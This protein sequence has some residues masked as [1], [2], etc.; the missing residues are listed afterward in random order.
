[1]EKEI[2]QQITDI[3]N[4]TQ[5]YLDLAKQFDEKTKTARY[6]GIDGLGL[7]EIGHNSVQVLLAIQKELLDLKPLAPALGCYIPKKDGSLR[8]I[9][10]YTIKDRIKAQAIYRVLEPI[11]ENLYSPFLFSY[12]SSHPSYYAARSVAR[13]YHRYYGQ[14]FI[15]IADLA[16]YFNQLDHQILL[17][18]LKEI[19][20][21]D[22][23]IDLLKLFIE[24]S[25]YKDNQLYTP[26]MGV[27]QGAPLSVLF[28][29]LYLNDLDKY[30]GTKVSLY[31]RVGDD[32]ILF[33]KN[34]AK[35]EE[36][37]NY[38]YQEVKNLK[39][40]IK[41]KKTKLI[42]SKES[43]DFLGYHFH[44]NLVSLD[45]SSIKK[46]ISNWRTNLLSFKVKNE[47]QKM[48]YLKKLITKK[49]NN[50]AN[51]FLQILSQ[52]MMVNDDQQIKKLSEKF[53]RILTKYFYGKY[54]AR[55]QRLLKKKL[56][57]F[58][59]PSI[60]KYYLNIHHGRKRISDLFVSAK[61]AH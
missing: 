5:A 4:I 59:L 28:A 32:L 40:K 3:E 31:R 14:D 60:Y 1:M 61:K 36:L 57:N 33:D 19:N 35:L 44:D 47:R 48:N 55:N 29:N 22:Q 2:F 18:K 37:R 13:R 30:L 50:L 6:A 17:K 21:S 58:S 9:F 51:Q 24:S 45:E 15:F 8:N 42:S 49:T 39:L 38:V 25:V 26:P 46:I 27:I 34:R 7:N 43:F 16:D 56:K 12:R 11:F 54:S 20:L 52:K 23:V 53:F 10:I 41:E